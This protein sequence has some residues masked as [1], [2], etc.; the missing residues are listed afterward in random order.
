MFTCEGQYDGAAVENLLRRAGDDLGLRVDS[1]RDPIP[2]GRWTSRESV[3]DL[4]EKARR[5][6]GV[7]GLLLTRDADDDCPRTTGPEAAAWLREVRLPF[8]A[9]VVLFKPEFEVLFLPGLPASV[10]GA[11]AQRDWEANRDCKAIV[12]RPMLPARRYKPSTDQLRL[13][14]AL[15]LGRLRAAGVPC[16]GTFENAIRFLASNWGTAG[17]GRAYPPA[18]A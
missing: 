6:P 5:R 16:Y 17:A 15:D 18:L 7:G 9:A 14:R 8:P 4:A 3:L 10:R 12:S 11:R 2:S 1:W 13:T